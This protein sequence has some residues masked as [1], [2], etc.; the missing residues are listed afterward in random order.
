MKIKDKIF[1]QELREQFLQK[2]IDEWNEKWQ[3]DF[4]EFESFE[5]IKNKNA[6]L[7]A[8][9]ADIEVCLYQ[10]LNGQSSKYLFSKDFLRRFIYEY[11]SKEA[12]IQSH[13]RSGIAIY[14]VY[15]GWEDFIEKNQ[16]N[17]SQNINI[18]YVNIDESLLPILLKNQSLVLDNQGFV[19]YQE[20][21]PKRNL[22]K[23]LFAFLGIVL[24]G[25]ISYFTFNWWQNRPFT[26]EDLNGIKFEII[27]TVGKYPQA[28]R[29]KYD[30]SS[31]PNVKNIEIETGV[32]K[33]VT[34]THFEGFTVVSNKKNDT[35]A[36]TY[37]F[38]GIYHLTLSV[39]NKVVKHLYHTV[40]SKRNLWTAWGF[41]VAYGKDWI[42]NINPT[43]NYIKGGIF[44]FDPNELPKEIKQED[45]LKNTTHVLVQDFGLN[46]DSTQMEAR[47]KNPQN[48]GGESCYDM[49][50]IFFDKNFNSVGAK[51]TTEGCTDFASLIV[52]KTYFRIQNN[53]RKNID[54]D[55][56]GVN[57]DE[58]NVFK[59]V[60]KG[61]IL[62]V[63]VNDKLAFKGAFETYEAC[64]GIVDA[65]L[66]FKGA[67]SID[68]V[69]VSNSYTGKVVYKTD[70]NE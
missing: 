27:K 20:L 57:Q 18:N 9:L 50:I 1:L 7:E 63:F 21:K 28:V 47:M 16:L 42:T 54:L 66:V 3:S 51:F 59:L 12:R 25:V 65:R 39:N 8:L 49:Q 23:Y 67:G 55:S 38:P 44:H 46:L 36:Q 48:E 29:I 32:G 24:I 41:G 68:W 69:K 33:I 60:V 11:G 35:L 19:N 30:V 40:Y 5:A 45:D 15:D 37:F 58:W 13:S 17:D 34:G 2:I 14:L 6:F 62:E 61:K 70:F 53:K 52:G 26:E 64:L 4:N 10:K 56:F 31:L 43:S 22:K